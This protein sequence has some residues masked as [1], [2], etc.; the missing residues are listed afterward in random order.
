MDARMSTHNFCLNFTIV[1]HIISV[2]LIYIWAD[3]KK[4]CR[5]YRYMHE[6]EYHS[7]TYIFIK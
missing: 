2:K 6:D 1:L 7:D 5:A 4:A 3:G